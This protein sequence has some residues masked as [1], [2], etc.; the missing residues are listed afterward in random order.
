MSLCAV[1]S[2][3]SEDVYVGIVRLNG[4]LGGGGGAVCIVIQQ[5]DSRFTAMMQIL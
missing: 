4:P 2:I 1:V 3:I 5:V